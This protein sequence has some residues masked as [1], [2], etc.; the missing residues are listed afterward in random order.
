MRKIAIMCGIIAYIGSRNSVPDLVSGIKKLEYRGYDSF[1][2]ALR[3]SNGLEIFKSIKTI[4]Q[5][6]HQFNIDKMTSKTAIF[7]TRWATNGGISEI[8]AHPQLDCDAKVAVVHNG[9]IENAESLKNRLDQHKFL[10]ETDTEVIP[11]IIEENLKAGQNFYESTVLAARELLGMSSFVA[12]HSDLDEMIAFKNGS[13]LIL[14]IDE[15][16]YFISSDIP[17]VINRTNRIIYLSD[18]DVVHLTKSSF[19]IINIYNV[20]HEHD[21]H[22]V[23]PDLSSTDEWNYPDLMVKEIFDQLSIWKAFPESVLQVIKEASDCVRNAERVY[24]VGSGSSYHVA[25]YGSMLLRSYG[26]DALGIQPQDISDF[27]HI[28][29]RDDIVFVISQSG[30]TADMIYFLKQIPEVR[31]IGIINVEHSHLANSVDVLIPMSVGIERAVAATKSVSNSMMII[32]NLYLLLSNSAASLDMDLNLLDLNKFNLVVP[33]I[34]NK[35][36]EI[37][38]LLKDEQNIFITGADKEYILAMEGAL[39]IKEV[40]YIHAEAL[41]LISLKHGPLAMVEEGTKVVV[42]TGVDDYSRNVDELK[43]RGAVIIGIA[44]KKYNNFDYFI[45]TVPAGIFSFAPILFILQLLSY[46]IAVKKGINPDK[47][48]NLAKSVTVR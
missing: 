26:K 45:R 9:I 13:P 14:A 27:K 20:R 18:G 5:G 15:A 36:K 38:E 31:K 24:F 37:A 22:Y 7:H 43:A 34:E 47:P 4:D 39:K 32:A 41:D 10:S 16:G 44:E 11:H 1:G 48:R 33:S 46:E 8:N 28:I 40:T 23:S 42:I 17:S 3:T 29:R 25:L 30:E 21:V 12:I 2:C 19:S 6:V 35:I